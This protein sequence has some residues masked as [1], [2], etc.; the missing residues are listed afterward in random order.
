MGSWRWKISVSE[1]ESINNRI[2]EMQERISDVED[3]V[4]KL[5]PLVKEKVKLKEFKHKIM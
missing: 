1:Y 5:V 3:M 4:G 2:L